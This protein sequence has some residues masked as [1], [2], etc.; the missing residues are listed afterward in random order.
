M[1]TLIIISSLLLGTSIF[2]AY[3]MWF[4]AGV[5]AEAQEYIEENQA[6]EENLEVTNRYMYFRIISSYA[7]N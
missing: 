1:I 4:L 2:F 6:Y 7:E 5:L 3:R